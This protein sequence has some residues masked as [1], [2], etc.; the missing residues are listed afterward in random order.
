MKKYFL[1]LITLFFLCLPPSAS[2]EDSKGLEELM[3]QAKVEKIEFNGQLNM[4]EVYLEGSPQP[5][6]LTGDYKYLFIGRIIDIKAKKDLIPVKEEKAERI[7][8]LE[9]SSLPLDTAVKIS[10]GSKKLAVFLDPDCPYSRKIY[11]ELKRLTDV[12]VHVFFYPLAFH[13]RAKEK[14]VSAW[15]AEN[16]VVAVENLFTKGEIEKKECPNPVDDHIALAMQKGLKGVPAMIFEDGRIVDG[17]MKA[18]RLMD[19]F[20]ETTAIK[21]AAKDGKNKEGERWE[22]EAGCQ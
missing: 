2:P 17:Y 13:P 12:S 6:Y 14:S 9:F 10:E 5:L 20:N 8:K 4:Y 1:L 16:K 18:E 19:Y 21:E 22:N 11:P 7:S 15:C 3:H